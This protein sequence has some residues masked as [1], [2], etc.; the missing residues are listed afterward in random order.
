MKKILLLF[1]ALAALLSL[2]G[3]G[4]NSNKLMAGA[5]PAT[6]A[7]SFYVCDGSDPDFPVRSYHMYDEATT[8]E[9]LEQ[10]ESVKVTEAPGWSPADLS[11]PVYGFSISD[12]EGWSIDGAWCNGFWVSGDG[13]VYTYDFDF[14]ALLGGYDWNFGSR[15]RS[16]TVLPCARYLMEGKDGWHTAL[17]T[18]S[19]DLTPPE[20]VTMELLGFEDGTLTVRYTNHGSEEWCF[21]EYYSLDVLLDGVWYVVPTT[22]GNWGFTDIGYLLSAGDSR[23]ESYSLTMYGTLPA[24]TYRIRAFDLS[25]DFV[26]E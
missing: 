11:G 1:T 15:F 7:L 24:G 6:S 9:I 20:G 17:M 12:T 8:R 3:C 22:P 18:P 26:I 5:S 25:A 10:L 4:E 2:G 16:T 13:S 19:G 23:E 21:G 14:E